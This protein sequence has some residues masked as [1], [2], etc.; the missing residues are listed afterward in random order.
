VSFNHQPQATTAYVTFTLAFAFGDL[1]LHVYDGRGGHRG[2]NYTTG[3]VETSIPGEGPDPRGNPESIR[4]PATPGVTYR[5]EVVDRTNTPSPGPLGMLRAFTIGSGTLAATADNTY[6]VTAIEEKSIGPILEV[7]PRE[8]QI[9]VKAAAS[10]AIGT[11]S[12][13]EIGLQA[14]VSSLAVSVGA[15][16][17]AAG[18]TILASEM[19]IELESA[20]LQPGE[21]TTVTVRVPLVGRS[22]FPYA[23]EITV[24]SS[25]GT[26]HVALTIAQEASRIRRRLRP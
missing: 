17:G 10:D 3:K 25:A 15:L 20:S 11:I 19:T 5:V 13:R 1:D 21:N 18:E 23:G 22:A 12:L 2:V 26:Q 4:V 6:R 7:S 14:G 24:T 16:T 9:V 8:L